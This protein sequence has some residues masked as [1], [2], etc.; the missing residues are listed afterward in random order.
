MSDTGQRFWDNL[1]QIRGSDLWAV[2]LGLVVLALVLHAI[3]SQ[4]TGRTL[5]VLAGV[6]IAVFVVGVLL[7]ANYVD[8]LMDYPWRP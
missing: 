4:D 8:T 2:P 3:W 5:K 6:G 7:A 1:F